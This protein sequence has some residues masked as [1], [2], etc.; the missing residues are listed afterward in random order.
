MGVPNPAI[1]AGSGEQG[2]A[3]VEGAAVGYPAE[4]AGGEKG[5]RAAAATG[6]GDDGG[7]A[8]GAIGMGG[9]GDLVAEEIGT[10]VGGLAAASGLPHAEHFGFGVK[11]FAPQWGQVLGGMSTALRVQSARG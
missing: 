8:V 1:D 2:E 4:G 3:D 5:V 10:D 6:T 11:F 9:G 7:L